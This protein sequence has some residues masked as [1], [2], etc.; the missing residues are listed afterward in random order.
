VPW[1]ISEQLYWESRLKEHLFVGGKSLSLGPG[2]LKGTISVTHESKSHH[3]LYAGLLDKWFLGHY[4]WCECKVWLNYRDANFTSPECV[5]L[6][7]ILLHQIP[8]CQASYRIFIV[9]SL[10]LW[11]VCQVHNLLPQNWNG[12]PDLHPENN[13]T[14]QNGDSCKPKGATMDHWQG[15][16]E[17][18][19]YL[20][21][22]PWMCPSFSTLK[23]ARIQP[24]EASQ[25]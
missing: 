19:M 20:C 8:P 14:S 12:T 16:I 18:T 6:R 13:Y 24:S 2:Q 1:P 17:W 21:I 4:V 25:M 23:V 7:R 10:D 9:D 15:F 5:E 3:I 11:L 22:G